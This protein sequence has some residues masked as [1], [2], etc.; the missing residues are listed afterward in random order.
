[1]AAIGTT[2]SYVVHM[3]FA[4]V[5]TGSVL[6]MTYGILPVAR[7]GDIDTDPFADIT[8]RLLTLSRA[9][10]LV[11]FLTGGHLAGVLYTVESLTGSTRGYL[12][13]AMIVL[14][15]SLA[16]LVEVGTSR[17]SDGLRER[18]V[19]TPAEKGRPFFLA[20]SVA[21]LGLLVVAGLLLGL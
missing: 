10:A 1:M 21:A 19:R 6:F 7:A 14:W 20:G 15:L 12:V 3:L 17:I 4:G 9:S 2:I 11:L 8:S 13:I 16:G 18:K 5:W